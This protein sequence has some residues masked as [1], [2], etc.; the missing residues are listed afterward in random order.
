MGILLNRHPLIL[1]MEHYSA[2]I[3]GESQH[4]SEK[5]HLIGVEKGSQIVALGRARLAR[6]SVFV[7]ERPAQAEDEKTT[8][9]KA[10]D[11]PKECFSK[12]FWFET[13]FL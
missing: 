4:D 9:D 10:Y 6:T 12:M 3:C 13:R 5:I 11:Q 7:R 8:R 1:K 2:G